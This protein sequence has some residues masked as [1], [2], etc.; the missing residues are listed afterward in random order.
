MKRKKYTIDYYIEWNDGTTSSGK[1]KLPIEATRRSRNSGTA[2]CQLPTEYF[3][4]LFDQL[5]EKIFM[6]S[7]SDPE[8]YSPE[9]INGIEIKIY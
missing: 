7:I 1:F 9:M 8:L 6:G 4:G 2:H 5:Y 3:Q